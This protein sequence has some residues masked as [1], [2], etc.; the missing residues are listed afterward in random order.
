MGKVQVLAVLSMDGCLAS[1]LHGKS[2][3]E[4]CLDCCGINEI[5]ENALYH[6]TPDYSISMLD[7]WR[8][9][10]TDTCYL[11][12]ASPEKTDYI[13]GLLRM[14]AVDEIILYTVP[15]ISGSGRH[16]FKSALPEQHWTL[17]SLKSYPN[18]VCRI[19][20]ILDKKAR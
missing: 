18:G 14:H 6:I 9:H 13:N 1:E 17:S 8:R 2:Y 5:K 19:I 16:F 7:E 15:F 3:K 4:L 11:A 20:Y 12:E 10:E